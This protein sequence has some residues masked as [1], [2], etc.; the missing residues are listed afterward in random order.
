[1]RNNEPSIQGGSNSLLLQCHFLSNRF[2]KKA[3]EVSCSVPGGH[4]QASL[5]IC[6]LAVRKRFVRWRRLGPDVRPYVSVISATRASITHQHQHRVAALSIWW[7][8]H[9]EEAR[10]HKPYKNGKEVRK[11]GQRLAW[12]VFTESLRRFTFLKSIKPPVLG[13]VSGSRNVLRRQR[14]VMRI[15]G[16]H[17]VPYVLGKRRHLICVCLFPSNCAPRN[18]P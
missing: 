3:T 7:C 6:S 16:R 9:G 8:F 15:D 11:Q 5:L 10:V 13:G 2:L 12:R 18:I 14:P 17:H 4:I 1:M